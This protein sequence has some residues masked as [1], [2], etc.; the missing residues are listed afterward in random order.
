MEIDTET[1]VI[2]NPM[3]D[4]PPPLPDEDRS[5]KKVKIRGDNGSVVNNEVREGVSF[6]DKLLSQERNVTSMKDPHYVEFE[7]N[8]DD[9]RSHRENGVPTIVFSDRIQDLMAQSLKQSV[10]VRLLGRTIV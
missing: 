2:D 1:M 4:A 6:K 10:I 8:S 5:T 9:V 7:I 3:K